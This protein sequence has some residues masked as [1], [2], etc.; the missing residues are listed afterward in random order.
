HYDKGKAALDRAAIVAARLI[1]DFPAE[2]EPKRLLADVH[3]HKGEADLLKGETVTEDYQKGIELLEPLL[4]TTDPSPEFLDTLANLHTDLGL[5]FSNS[6]DI[7]QAATHTR[8]AIKLL[9]RAVNET[10]DLPTKLGLMKD[11][12]LRHGNLGA[13]LLELSDNEGAAAEERQAIALLT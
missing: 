6:G 12:A 11:L 3:L 8:E 1:E 13:Q 4:A 5:S 10:D 7:G 9:E 2:A